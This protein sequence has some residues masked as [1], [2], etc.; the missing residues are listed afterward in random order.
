MTASASNTSRNRNKLH[1]IVQ[2]SKKDKQA[3]EFEPQ[4]DTLIKAKERAQ[5][6]YRF[7]VE[8]GLLHEF[9]DYINYKTA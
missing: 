8:N 6:A 3:L 5:K 7:I 2:L 9:T 1:K 4:A